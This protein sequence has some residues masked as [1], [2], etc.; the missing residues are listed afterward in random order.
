[1]PIFKDAFTSYDGT[2]FKARAVAVE[3]GTEPQEDTQMGDQFRSMAPGLDTFSVEIE[4][5]WGSTT[6]DALFGTTAGKTGTFIFRPT[7]AGV[8]S[9]NPQ[10]SGVMT[11]TNY[12]L[13]GPVGDQHVG[14]VSLVAGGDITRATST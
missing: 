7:T 1:M 10:Y 11:R 6:T 8:S 9:T 5:N 3:L 12:T 14:S 2:V 4:F 13:G